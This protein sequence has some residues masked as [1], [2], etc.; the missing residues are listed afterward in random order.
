MRDQTP[1]TMCMFRIA[2]ST[3]NDLTDYLSGTTEL[4]QNCPNSF[5]PNLD[6]KNWLSR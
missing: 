4:P 2:T 1:K 3:Y 5:G 6:I